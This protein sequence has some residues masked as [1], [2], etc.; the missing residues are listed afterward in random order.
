MSINLL[1]RTFLQKEL[2][3][4]IVSWTNPDI[5]KNYVVQ[6]NNPMV[7][8]FGIERDTNG[9][10]FMSDN[11]YSYCDLRNGMIYRIKKGFKIRDWN[12]YQELYEAGKSSGKFRIDIPLH[13]EEISLENVLWEYAEL[14]SPNKD[15]GCNF[16]DD[17][18]S[19]PELT[20]GV[21]PNAGIDDAMR[22]SVKEYFKQ[23]MDQ[24]LHVAQAAFEIAKRNSCGM[25]KGI[26]EPSNRYKD[27]AGYFWSDFDHE[28]WVLNQSEIK[29]ISMEVFGAALMFANVC[30][31][32]NHPRIGELIDYA[33]EKWT[34]I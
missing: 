10:Y 18:F 32:L 6:P 30:G 3:N 34:T 27:A 33:R 9:Y 4:R 12:C 24:S 22:D 15:Y 23:Y 19:W 8:D 2:Q 13:R 16:N 5:R 28:E 1:K 25:P 26:C 11:L 14:Q 17:V 7:P 20:D 31:V 29:I 21:K